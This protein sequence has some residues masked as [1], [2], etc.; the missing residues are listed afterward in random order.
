[1]ESESAYPLAVRPYASLN[2]DI[3]KYDREKMRICLKRR[4]L[5]SIKS[6]ALGYI[7]RI[8]RTEEYDIEAKLHWIVLSGDKR[9]RKSHNL[10]AVE[11]VLGALWFDPDYRPEERGGKQS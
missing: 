2:R 4:T 5:E 1:M 7:E 11:S 6:T 3:Q 10:E 9:K 8:K